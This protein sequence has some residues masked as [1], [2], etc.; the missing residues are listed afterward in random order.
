MK[1][2]ND[3]GIDISGIP[4][5]FWPIFVGEL[6]AVFGGAMFTSDEF[7]TSG[8]VYLTGTGGWN[9]AL[10]R[11]CKKSGLSS[12]YK[13]YCKMPWYVSDEFDGVL[14]DKLMEGCS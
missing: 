6:Y 11:A 3:F 4:E 14:A 7:G 5:N 8:L 10:K 12:L 9:W 2:L 1:T 13:Q